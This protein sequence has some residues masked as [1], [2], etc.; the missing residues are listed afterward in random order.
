MSQAPMRVLIAGGG[1][2][3]LCLAQ[4]LHQ[5]GIDVAVFERVP[6][7]DAFREGYRIHLDPD[8][9]RAL[10]SCLPDTQFQLLQAGC[11][12][13]PRSFAFLT[14]QLSELMSNDVPDPDPADPVAIHRSINRFTLR[15]ILLEGLADRV[16]FGKE[17]LR[18][19]RT[20]DGTITA[21]FADGTVETGTLLVGAEGGRSRVR[22]QLLPNAERRD[23]GTVSIAGR[24]TLNARVRAALPRHLSNG[25]A[26]IL[27]PGGFN[28]FLATHEHADT[29]TTLPA[30]LLPT[31][32]TDYLVWAL[33]ARRN[34]FAAAQ[35]LE[36]MT[37][38]TLHH[39]AT[40]TVSSW[41][42]RLRQLV[43]DTD[44]ATITLTA[45]RTAAPVRPWP[46]SNVTLLGDAIHSMPPSRGVGANTALRDASLLSRKL[47]AAA[48]RG[49]VVAAVADYEDQ[50]RRYGFAA[51][52]ASQQALAQSVIA[53]PIAFT[54]SKTM[55]RMV[56][57]VLSAK[58]RLSV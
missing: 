5:A 24:V 4:G 47:I 51:V 20:N 43:Q 6:S 46:A 56:G 39:L 25:V 10:H 50:M 22:S 48:E 55:L 9:S 38:E 57:L 29:S 54:A 52:K 28:M 45:I 44:P 37:P 58:R 3:G 21:E 34:S 16:H 32:N 53:N 26:M 42:G 15:Q 49:D 7:A 33:T 8:G 14:E 2:G 23:T 12:R 41:Q 27:A 19:Q 30:H 17:F 40:A 18:Y 13:A 31:T 11:G 36:N 35:P 1:I